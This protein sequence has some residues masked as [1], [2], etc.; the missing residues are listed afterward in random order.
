MKKIL[1]I[2]V[3]VLMLVSTQGF[4]KTG[5]GKNNN[6]GKT[7]GIGLGGGTFTSGISAKY[8]MGGGTALQGILGARGGDGFA[9]GLDFI[10][11]MPP[12]LVENKD[13][14]LNWY[15]GFGGSIWHYSGHW[16]N[17]NYSWNTFGISGVVGLALMLQKVPL[18]FSLE[19][20]PTF[21][22]SGSDYEWY[23]GY[24]GFRLFDLAGS[25]RWFF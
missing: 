23:E 17:D 20:R 21:Y 14:S 2:L 1:I 3:L 19:W 10:I 15:A 18:E 7:F 13:V 9:L 4:A 12:D 25:V 6:S 8:N 11:N 24:S 5:S 16:G 22:I